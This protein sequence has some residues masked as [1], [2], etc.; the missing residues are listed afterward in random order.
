MPKGSIAVLANSDIGF[1]EPIVY[2][3][4]VTENVVYALLRWEFSNS[5]GAARLEPRIDSQD[6]WIFQTPLK[7]DMKGLNFYLGQPRCDNRLA[8]VFSEQGVAVENPAF[9]IRS[10]HHQ[11]SKDRAYTNDDHVPGAIKMVKLTM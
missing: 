8:A 7:M 11:K 10:Y 3:S 6:V 5:D 1:D 9:R 2:A 4:R